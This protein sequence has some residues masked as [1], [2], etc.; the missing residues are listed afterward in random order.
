MSLQ[1]LMALFDDAAAAGDTYN[2]ADLATT[3][4]DQ[5]GTTTTYEVAIIFRTDATVD[6]TRLVGSTLNDEQ[7]D[8]TDG[9]V[10]DC[11]VRCTYVSG[12]TMTGGSSLGT[13]HQCS[14]QRSFIMTH[15]TAG[16]EDLLQ[17]TFKFE[18]ASDASGT[19][20]EADSG[21]IIVTVGELF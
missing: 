11:W 8:Y 20:I 21:N 7:V 16:G 1:M 17:G 6:V 19:P 15:T 18:L 5:A 9:A 4:S 12:D 10:A 14:T 3:Y 2:L 13:W